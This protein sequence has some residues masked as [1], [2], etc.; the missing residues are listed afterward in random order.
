MQME[1]E[2][3]NLIHLL[4]ENYKKNKAYLGELENRYASHIDNNKKLFEINSLFK[5]AYGVV[6]NHKQSNRIQLDVS[7]QD[8]NA[9]VTLFYKCLA[10]RK[11]IN[12]IVGELSIVE[13]QNNILAQE[14]KILHDI[15]IKSGKTTNSNQHQAAQD[16]I[17]AKLNLSEEDKKKILNILKSVDLTQIK[18]D[19]DDLTQK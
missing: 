15:G 1:V 19:I 8:K 14:N 4:L 11:N 7:N 9:I 17:A 12:S 5:N 3:L 13:T 18:D 2:F 16:L 10:M 6:Q